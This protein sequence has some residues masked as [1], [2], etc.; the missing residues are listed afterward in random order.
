V[1]VLSGA[2]SVLEHPV[3][4]GDYQAL[5]PFGPTATGTW[6]LLPAAP[7]ATDDGRAAS[8][9]TGDEM[10]VVGRVH[11]TP[12]K[13][14]TVAA[15]YDPAT[16]TW[17][18]LAPPPGAAGSRGGRLT[19]VWTGRELLGWGD[20][21]ALSYTPRTNRWRLLPRAPFARPDGAVWTGGELLGWEVSGRAAAYDPAVNRWRVLPRSPLQGGEASGAWAGRELVLVRGR[22]G[23]AYDPRSNR[24]RRIAPPPASHVGAEA[25]WDGRDILLV[26]GIGGRSRP[27]PD[28]AFAYDARAD[29]WRRLRPMD[30]GRAGAAVVWTGKRLLMWGGETGAGSRSVIP[31]HGVAYDPRAD[32]WSPLRQAPLVGRIRPTAVWTGRSMIVWGG[33]AADSGRAFADGAAFTPATP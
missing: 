8:V 1:N 3:R 26:G 9:W 21:V 4:R 28:A 5:S 25:V 17:R 7:I 33:F 16:G 14:V 23:A 10:V 27:L 30:F 18:R 32:R 29:S 11:R 19:A 22:R 2:G 12:V 24:W 31:P 13:S 20:R 15:T 6:R